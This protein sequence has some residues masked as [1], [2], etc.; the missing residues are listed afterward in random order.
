VVLGNIIGGIV[1]TAVET[2]GSRWHIHQGYLSDMK[3]R[4]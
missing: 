1:G 3:R 4:A 2:G